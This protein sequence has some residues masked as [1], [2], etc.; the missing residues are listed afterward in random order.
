MQFNDYLTLPHKFI[1]AIV[2]QYI[3][4]ITQKGVTSSILVTRFGEEQYRE[5]LSKYVMIMKISAMKTQLSLLDYQQ[6]LTCHQEVTGQ[7]DNKNGG[8][9]KPD[10][11]YSNH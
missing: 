5:Y 11:C 2:S 7:A 10:Q 6:T 3:P 9:N 4:D 8:E 1:H